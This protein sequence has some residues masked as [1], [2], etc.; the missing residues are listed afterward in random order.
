MMVKKN[1]GNDPPVRRNFQPDFTCIYRY[2]YSPYAT[3]IV[4][5]KCI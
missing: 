2:S 3:A 4:Y 5:M 1:D